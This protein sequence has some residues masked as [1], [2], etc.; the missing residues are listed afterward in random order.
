[1]LKRTAAASAS[2]SPTAVVAGASALGLA[3][4]AKAFYSGAP[5]GD[6]L[7]ILA[8]SAWLARLIGGIDLAYEPGAGFISHTYHLI[9]GPS[10]AG[11]NFLVICFLTLYFSFAARCRSR[12]RWF[13]SS[14]AVALAAAI[15]ANA[16]RIAVAAHLWD[17]GFYRSWMTQ[18]EMHRVAG[19]V[20]YYGSLMGLWASV[21]SWTRVT[22]RRASR[23]APL[24]WYVSI[25]LG[26]PLMH[27]LYGRL[28][29]EGTLGFS[30]HAVWV[31]GIVT[32]VTMLMFFP[33]A[34]AWRVRKA[35]AGHDPSFRRD[36]S[37]RSPSSIGMRL[38][39]FMRLDHDPT[40][41]SWFD[42]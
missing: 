22:P 9:V 17:A 34:V 29:G 12:M 8:P 33:S 26:V 38:R 18:E 40:G 42:R 16:L 32:L 27:R 13:A 39:N 31:L 5:A 6:L 41:A 37:F 35:G 19:T 4:A 20:I 23:L 11:I 36:K 25:S 7:W 24:A 15:A 3:V 28:Y 21:D 14:A 30:E 2:R 1:M 10:C